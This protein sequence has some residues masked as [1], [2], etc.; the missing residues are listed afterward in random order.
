M[1]SGTWRTWT[2]VNLRRYARRIGSSPPI[3][4][5]GADTDELEANEVRAEIRLRTYGTNW[6]DKRPGQR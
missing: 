5:T 4:V 3:V 1:E 6:P 2:G